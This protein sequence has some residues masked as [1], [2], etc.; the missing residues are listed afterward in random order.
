MI[1]LN[2]AKRTVCTVAVF[3]SIYYDLCR[4]LC[5]PTSSTVIKVFNILYKPQMCKRTETVLHRNDGLFHLYPYFVIVV[6]C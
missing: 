5:R 4:K 6:P 2:C 3:K 1:Y